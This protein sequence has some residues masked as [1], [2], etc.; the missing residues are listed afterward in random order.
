MGRG[1]SNKSILS[2]NAGELSPKLDARMDLDKYSSGCRILENAFVEPYGAAVRRPGTEYIAST[3]SAG[4]KARLISFN[5]ST[6]TSYLLEVGVGYM[7]FY[8]NGAQVL[9]DVAAVASAWV[10]INGYKVGEYVVRPGPLYYRCIQEVPAR[11]VLSLIINP[12]PVD[13]TDHWEPVSAT[14]ISEVAAPWEESE[15]FELQTTQINDVVYITHPLH[16]VHK[17]SRVASDLFT[18]TVMEPYYPPLLDEN[19]D[20]EK[21]LRL[22]DASITTNW[23]TAT[24]Y[25]VGDVRDEGGVIYICIVS[26]TSGTFATD[27]AAGKWE[28]YNLLTATFAAFESG[29]VGSYWQLAHLREAS[30]V[31]LEI[32]VPVAWVETAAWVTATD[33]VVGDK[34]IEDGTKYVCLIDHT[35]GTFATDLAALKW[36]AVTAYDYVQ[37]DI[38]RHEDTNYVCLIDHVALVFADDLAAGK[39]AVSEADLASATIAVRGDWN[40]RTYGV[41]IADILL[42]R[43][44]DGGT[45]WETIRKFRG[46]E[47]RNVDAT[48]NQVEEALFRVV[49]NDIDPPTNAGPTIPRIIIESV[50]AY[51]Y[52]LVQILGVINSTNCRVR[53]VD[54][55]LSNAETA[56]WSEGAWSDVRGYPRAVTLHEQRLCFGGTTYQAQT[57]WGSVTGDFENFKRGTLDTDSFAYTLGAAEFN[58]ILW[59]VSQDRLLI[60]TTAAEWSMWSGDSGIPITPSS[61]KVTRHAEFGSKPGVS[62]MLVNDVVLFVQR[63]GRKLRELSYSFQKDGYVAPDLTL[64]SEH[65]TAGGIVQFAYQGGE[66][67]QRIWA[68]TGNG[69]LVCMTYQRDQEVTA[70]ARQVTNGIV[71]SVATVYGAGNDE[72][73]LVVQRFIGTNNDTPVRYLER[74]NPAVWTDKEDAFFVDC[75]KT[76]VQASSVTV[77]GLSHLEGKTVRALADGNVEP[78]KVVVGG[79]ITLDNPA[80]KIHVGLHYRT[81]IKPM[82]IDTDAALGNEQGLIKQVRNLVLRF[83]DTLGAEYGDGKHPYERLEFRDTDDAMDTSPALFTGEKEVQFPGELET[84]GDIVVQQ[85]HPLPMTLVAIVVKHRVTGK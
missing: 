81:R 73:W 66:E 56:F 25:V 78:F 46:K 57:V 18:L 59:F 75:G 38:R 54:E 9:I 34:V 31:E 26:H 4:T 5:F 77:S 21:T 45:T 80:T 39:W 84:E 41:W 32:T 62:A 30:F 13:D 23:V 28:V 17:L 68:V 76:I 67:S 3:K 83:I 24:N 60:G 40:V 48:G 37:G 19:V 27:L 16:P 11:D 33:Y 6:T 79:Q 82:R 20:E 50:D 64:L 52:G 10:N 61:V 36:E 43:S 2:F 7:R 49:L 14:P 29:H 53:I 69:V 1:I 22:N 51:I 44:F 72:V 8:S 12:F 85:D 15:L 42:Q 63:Q 58:A 47:D 71:E 35:S 74:L 55:P 70:W 65:V